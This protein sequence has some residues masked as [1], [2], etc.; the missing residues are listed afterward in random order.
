M[1]D[2]P[3]DRW[4]ADDEPAEPAA[5][6]RSPGRARRPL[7]LL[8]AGIVLVAT[9]IGVVALSRRSTPIHRSDP[10]VE[11][12]VPYWALDASVPD[13]ALD[14]ALPH[15]VSPFWFSA[16]SAT[17]IGPDANAP[18]DATASFLRSAASGGLAVVPSVFDGMPAGGM[19]AVIS[20]PTSRAA[21][22]DA[23]VAFAAAGRYAGLDLDYEQFAFADPRSSWA[24]TRPH[25]VEFVTELANRLHADGRT[26]TVSVPPVYDQ[27]RTDDSGYW[28]YDYAGIAAAVDRIRVMAYDY[29]TSTP[30]PIAPLDWVKR[31]VDGAARASGARDKL[32]LGVPL[33]GYNWVTSTVG[34]CPATA[35]TGR[36]TVTQRDLADLISRRAASP[37]YDPVTGESSFSYTL[38][39][40]D[41]TNS[42]TQQRTV[43]FID[44]AG[45]MARIQIARDA[46]FGAISLWAM[47]YEEPTFWDR[48]AGPDGVG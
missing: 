8:A 39:V 23:L 47:G 43:R 15:T 2:D 14:V 18:A 10:T 22:V 7:A 44:A 40:T 32:A 4:R 13:L 27:G 38:P 6:P 31:S 5:E 1:Q 25:W 36:A 16:T 12:W 24:T 37:V 21:H 45:T 28:V 19:A 3:D 35:E 33:Y 41:A 29:S 42:C 48:L 26:L 17:A 9:L 34:T 11:A 46:G 30:G 20:D